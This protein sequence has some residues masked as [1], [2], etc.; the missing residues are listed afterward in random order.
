MDSFLI[1]R[2][3]HLGGERCFNYI[4]K[5]YKHKHC[6]KPKSKKGSKIKNTVKLSYKGKQRNKNKKPVYKCRDEQEK[7]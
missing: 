3:V 4:N 2:N 5:G 6:R 1:T 7:Y